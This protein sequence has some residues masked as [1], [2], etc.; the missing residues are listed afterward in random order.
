MSWGWARKLLKLVSAFTIYW[1]LI[2]QNYSNCSKHNIEKCLLRHCVERQVGLLQNDVDLH[3]TRETPNSKNIVNLTRAIRDYEFMHQPHSKPNT[4]T[5][6]HLYMSDILR[7]GKKVGHY[8]KL[9]PEFSEKENK[10]WPF[11]SVRYKSWK[12]GC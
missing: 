4:H 12:A 9:T 3:F 6:T 11:P 2:I 10:N 5:H 8:V 7:S 1:I